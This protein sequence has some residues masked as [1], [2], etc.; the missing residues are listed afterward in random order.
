MPEG[1]ISP[2]G[3]GEGDEIEVLATLK[4][5]AG[6]KACLVEIDGYELAGYEEEG[7]DK[8]TYAQAAADGFDEMMSRQS[9]ERGG[10]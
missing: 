5:E 1:F 4:L 6:G 3:H 7:E 10:Y 2:E 9:K 8:R